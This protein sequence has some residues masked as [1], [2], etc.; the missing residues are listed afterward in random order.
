M[1]NR[2]S[3]LRVIIFMGFSLG[4]SGC[5]EVDEMPQLSENT[6][7]EQAQAILTDLQ[8]DIENIVGDKSCGGNT[9]CGIEPYGTKACGGP[10][11]YIIYGSNIDVN[12]L[13]KKTEQYTNIE[14]QMNSKFGIISTC[15][16]LLIPEVTCVDGQCAVVNG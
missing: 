12:V 4:L 10:S 8:T 5:A 2:F 13:L 16:L 6:T 14:G 9:T 15:D 11:R 1:K 7:L 3:V